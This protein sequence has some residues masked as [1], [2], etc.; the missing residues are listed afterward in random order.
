MFILTLTNKEKL[1]HKDPQRI[2]QIQNELITIYENDIV[3]HN[4]KVSSG[5][6]LL[7]FRSIV[8]QLAKTNEKFI[9]GSLK[10]AQEQESLKR[11]LNGW[12]LPG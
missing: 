10:K 1:Q 3:K 5:R 2:Q 9:Y 12:C 11:P 4:G 6:I 8:S 7:V